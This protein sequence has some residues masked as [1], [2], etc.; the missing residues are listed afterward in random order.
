LP[1][2][3]VVIIWLIFGSSLIGSSLWGQERE[4]SEPVEKPVREAIDIRQAT[5]QAEER[6][7]TERDRLT[8]EY[9]ALQLEHQRLEETLQTLRSQAAGV[10]ERIASK[11]T[12]LTDIEKISDQIEPFLHETVAKIEQQ[13]GKGTPFLMAERR[14]RLDKLQQ[15]MAEPDIAVSEKFRKVMEALLIEAE[16][17]HTIETDQQ[18][19]EV[20]GRTMLVSLFRLGRVSVF[21]QTLD[22]KSCGHYDPAEA[23]FRPLPASY[24]RAIQTAIDIGSRRRP[25]EMLCLPLGRIKVP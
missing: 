17:G 4:W 7:R 20:D 13:L 1:Y 12:Q 23:A 3:I 6:W 10:R 2:R 5:Q 9:E 11:E 22:R 18:T 24:N 25:V 8:A 19:I 21:Y 14:Q 16:Y 15:L